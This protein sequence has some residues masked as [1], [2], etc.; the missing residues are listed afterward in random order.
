MDVERIDS[1]HYRVRAT[2]GSA[3]G[4]LIASARIL[5]QIRADRSL[6]QLAN[7]ASLPGLVGPA[8]AMPDVHQGYGFPI[9]GVAAM[10]LE[11]GVVSPGGVGFDINCGV[12]LLRSRLKEGDVRKIQD[13]LARRLAAAVP[14]G[15]GE[16]GPYP[17]SFEE[18]D[19][20][21]AEGLRWAVAS[22]YATPY[23]QEHC[24]SR[25]TLPGAD[26][27]AV[28]DRAKQRGRGQLGTLGA[29]NHFLEV[30]R[31]GQI[32]DGE[33]A[34]A[35]GL[36]LGQVVVLIHCGSRGLGHQVCTDSVQQAASAM[37]R[38][39][40]ELP[41][42][43]LACVPIRS[44]EGQRYLAA[45]AAAGNFAFVNRQMISH[46][47]AAV[48]R[49]EFGSDRGELALV[50]DVAHNLAK[51]ETHVIDGRERKVLVH[52]K[53]A[54]RAFPPGHPEVP[55]AYRA[56]GQPVL[57]PGDMA[58][59]SYVLVGRPGA[60]RESFGSVCHGAGR[61]LS[62]TAAR[63]Q[64]NAHEIESE[65]R[66]HGIVV[67]GASR[68]GITEEAPGAYKDVADV[69]EVVEGAGLAARVARLDPLVVIKG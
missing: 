15:A 50:Y 12:R 23:D 68:A 67:R 19:R 4:I 38:Y 9:G 31:V 17:L 3:W 54:T 66:E 46:S 11:N 25:G 42:R 39:G 24:E 1:F 64:F 14:S 20:V 65:M 29:G 27:A 5:E 41:D 43:E 6:E 52:R 44:P 28:S 2:R 16:E 37:K 40:I 13:A 36:E 62:R 26:P 10:D 63:R 55:E 21:L 30:Q 61:I 48:F 22:G 58:R 7:V 34:A 69:V 32:F 47:V 51:I 33:A 57:I 35:F 60:M 8:L 53:G 18:L 56:I 49:E 45:M 59:Y